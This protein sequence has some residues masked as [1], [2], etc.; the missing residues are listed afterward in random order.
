MSV[1]QLKFPWN[2]EELDLL[3]RFHPEN[4]ASMLYDD[5]DVNKRNEE[6]QNENKDTD[7]IIKK[8]IGRGKRLSHLREDDSYIGKQI[9]ETL[10]K[11]Y[12]AEKIFF[13]SRTSRTST[14]TERSLNNNNAPPHASAFISTHPQIGGIKVLRP[15]LINDKRKEES[16][17]EYGMKDV[18]KN[19]DMN[20]TLRGRGRGR[21]A[22][23]DLPVGAAANMVKQ[24][25]G[26]GL[27][28][29][30][31]KN[32]DDQRQTDKKEK[33]KNSS[34]SYYFP[35]FDYEQYIKLRTW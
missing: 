15:K 23:I 27:T 14:K 32:Q 6:A 34:S 2:K 35:A 21:K 4:V 29:R 24:T 17:N 8:T 10:G 19:Y 7:R 11:A 22:N 5:A 1:K 33:H 28:S 13:N 26:Q 25:V 30:M 20:S 9:E 12:R 18:K 3:T 16:E 31:T